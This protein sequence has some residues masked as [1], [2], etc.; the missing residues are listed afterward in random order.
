M[1]ALLRYTLAF[2]GGILLHGIF[3]KSF[4][5]NI[6]Y[7]FV[8][9]AVLF[10]SALLF[11]LLRFRKSNRYSLG[12]LTILLFVGLGWVRTPSL[13]DKTDF[14]HVI[15]YEVAVT[16]PPETRAKTYKIEAMVLKAQWENQ[17]H[18]LSG[19]ILLYIDKGAPKPHYGDVLLIRG[20]PRLVEP[21]QNPAQFDYQRFLSYKQ[22]FHQHYLRSTDFA[23]TGKRETNWLKEWAFTVSEWSDVALRRLVPLDR[24]YAVAKAMI[25]GLRDEMDNEL[26][27]AYS[28]AGAV[29]VLSVSGFHVGIFVLLLAWLLRFIK[30]RRHGLFLYLGITLGIMWFYAVLTGLSA[31]VV[32]SAL[33]V[34]ILLLAEPL[35]KTKD[36]KNA[37]FGSALIL[38]VLDPLLIYSVSFQLSYAALGGILFWQPVLYQ[39]L[40]F[41][42]WFLDKI[43]E[44]S[45]AALTAQLAT[46][47]LAVY[48]FHQ[49]PTYF[50]LV[51]PV[52][53]GL[54]VAMLYVAFVTLALSWIPFLSVGL[55]WLLTMLT[56]LLN[57]A[58]VLTEQ[59]PYSV[60]GNLSFS[61]LELLLVYGIGGCLLALLYYRNV[62]WFCGI[63]IASVGLLI[64]QVVE[65]KTF[66]KQKWLV[67]HSVPK[68]SAVSLIDGRQA[69]LVADSAFFQPDQKPFNFYLKNFYVNQSIGYTQYEPLEVPA[70]DVKILPF[71]KL[72]VWQGRKILFVEKPIAWT[73]PPIA[74][75]IL[76]R[77]NAFRKSEQLRIVF[78]NQRLIFDNSNKFYVL[79]TL[80]KQAVSRRL[81]WY[82]VNK[83]GALVA[84]F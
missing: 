28:A 5:G 18:P 61:R 23:L 32:R 4:V 51:N 63:G 46:F 11:L 34:T 81:P 65:I 24:E 42:D 45:A 67:I 68:Q 37:L 14:S 62:R 25:L 30:K 9:G 76:I 82:F 43:W 59:L 29:H 21:P 57:Q 75:Y 73:L 41:K 50:L 31:P 10:L 13:H 1:N 54:S 27:Q 72:I 40:T 56:W 49:F 47:P 2:V 15:A 19:K 8:F 77:N 55:G 12:L 33:M 71:G 17:W 69:V 44:V 22:I 52:V 64:L 60:L 3:S 79:D 80:E 36:T 48:Y 53:V 16:S 78:G 7:K 83:K 26:V 38:L 20:A 35:G 70:A 6:G 84:Q 74:D 66:N 58:V 39:S